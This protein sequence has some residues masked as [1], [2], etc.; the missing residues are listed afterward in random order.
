MYSKPRAA[1]FVLF[2]RQGQ[3]NHNST[4]AEAHISYPDGETLSDGG[5]GGAMQSSS[6]WSDLRSTCLHIPQSLGLASAESVWWPGSP[7]RAQCCRRGEWAA[8]KRRDAGSS[9]VTLGWLEFTRRT[10]TKGV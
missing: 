5:A 1:G 8:A 7:C 3:R 6:R 10:E 4:V 9:P 2:D